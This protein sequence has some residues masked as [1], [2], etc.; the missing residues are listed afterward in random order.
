MMSNHRVVLIGLLLG[1]VPV[2]ACTSVRSIQPVAYLEDHAPP[3]VWVTYTNNT[4][5]PIA[6]PDFKRDTLRGTL[7]GARIKIPMGE[8]QSVEARVHD[9]RKTAFLLTGLGVAAISSMYFIFISKAGSNTS[10]QTCGLDREGDP[11]LDC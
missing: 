1:V 3:V 9:G 2:G 5:V 11:L 6:D 7:Q 4:V 8:I 10:D